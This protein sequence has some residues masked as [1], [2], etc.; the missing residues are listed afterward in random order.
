MIKLRP[1]KQKYAYLI[2]IISSLF[3]IHYTYATTNNYYGTTGDMYGN[4]WNTVDNTYSSA[5]DVTGG[6]ILNF[7]NATTTAIGPSS[8]ITV[9][10]INVNANV[11]IGTVGAGTITNLSNGAVTITVGTGNTFD[12]STQTFSGNATV[13][14]TKAGAGVFATNGNSYSGGF[15]LSAGTIMARGNN[16]MGNGGP[17][18][19]NGGTIAA[20]AARDFSGKYTGITIGGDFTLGSTTG[21][22]L[23]SA[24]LTFNTATSLGTAT[25]TITLG[26]TGAYTLSGV[27]SETSTAGLTVSSTAAGT[28]ILGGAN[29]YTGVTTVNSGVLLRLTNASALGTIAGNTVVNSGGGL[30]LN[31]INYST[32]EP[33]TINGTGISSAGAINNSGSAIATFAGPIT[34][35]TSS[36]INGGVYGTDFTGTVSG[37]G[38]LTITGSGG[39][40]LQGA[41]SYTGN[42]TKANTG[43]WTLSSTSNSYSGSTTLTAGTLCLG[44]AGVIP[45]GSSISFNGGTLCTGA[46]VGYTETVNL[47]NMT[48]S[49]TIALGTGSHNLI[50]ADSHAQSWTASTVL[51]IT[52]WNNT[53]GGRIYVGSNSSGL[54]SGQLAMITFSGYAAGAAINAGTGEITPAGGAVAPTLTADNSL[55]TVDNNIDITFSDSPVWRAAVTAVNIQISNTPTYTTL[56]AGTDY[57]LTSGHLL[58]KPSGG[59]S[60]LNSTAAINGLAGGVKPIVII[61]TGYANSTISQTIDNGVATQLSINAQPAAPAS[62]GAVLATQPVVKTLDQYG[63]GT[64]TTADVTATVSA[65]AWEIGGTLTQT[66][67]GRLTTFTDLVAY[68]DAAVTGATIIFSSTGLTSVTSGTFNIPV[69]TASP[70]LTAAV[71]ATVDAAFD[72][73]FTDVPAWRSAIRKITVGGTTLAAGAYNATV[74]GKI[75]F[76]PSVSTLLQSNGTKSI[77]I[78]STGYSSGTVSQAIGV[79]A[80]SASTSTA[81]IDANLSG[82]AT[83]TIT[84]TAKDQYNNLVSGYVFKYDATI[85]NSN[86]T[87]TES[88]TIDGVAKTA[89]ANDL[90]L[91]VTN[92]AG[93][94]TFTVVMPVTIDSGDGLVIQVQLNNGSTNVGSDFGNVLVAQTITFGALSNKINGD[95]PFALTATASS[96]LAVSYSSSDTNVATVS[97]STVTIVGVGS[98]TITASQAGDGSYTAA[99]S[100]PQGLNI[101]NTPNYTISSNTNISTLITSSTSDIVVA[102][103][104]TLTIDSNKLIHDL[105]VESGAKVNFSGAYTLSTVGNVI[106]KADKSTGSFSVNLGSGALGITGTSKFLKTMDDTKWFF[107]S[108]P[109]NIA[110]NNITF[111]GGYSYALGTDY[112]IKYYDGN[113]RI[114]NL[115]ASSNWKNVT[116]GSTLNAGDG[117]IFGLATGIG[118][119]REMIFPLTNA[120][121]QS[122]S[123]RT[124]NVT[125][126]GEGVTT[127]TL[128]NT[129]GAN[130]KGWN[131]V[132]QPYISKLAGTG[133]GVNYMTLY[134][135]SGYTTYAN[136]DVTTLD[137]FTSFFVQADAALQSSA[138]T[139]SLASRQS[140]PSS[141]KNDT[142]DK[143]RLYFQTPTGIDNTNLVLGDHQTNDYQIGQDMEKWITRGTDKPQVYTMLNGINYAFN[144]LPVA[145]VQNLPLGV[146]TNATGNATISTDAQSA[147]NLTQL[148]LTDT[149]NGTTTDLL[150]SIYSFTVDA[151]T[152]N[153]RFLLSA[154]RTSTEIPKISMVQAYCSVVSGKLLINKLTSKSK[155]MVYDA[156]GSL[157]ASELANSSTI[158]MALPSKGVY[159]VQFINAST[160]ICQKV[161][162]R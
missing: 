19:I 72:V 156:F 153:G 122:E 118:G 63:N 31:G 44:A 117:Y 133:V 80:V 40:S 71:G 22:A 99:S 97:G 138:V 161:I 5:M 115:G 144:A 160:T 85:T 124:V 159:I 125:A 130:H 26:G 46:T 61:A 95:V 47:L 75:T 110:V 20:T 27:I 94:K 39:G 129:V 119:D 78:Y 23:S 158:E 70:A 43:T 109:S 120:D 146:Y 131:L 60:Y 98:T 84:C 37:T 28:L 8:N 89:T 17:L 9:A 93:V 137:P 34:L 102:S 58:L 21:L 68:S 50:F 13:S 92:G 16:T 49:S 150:T 112:F 96:G 6:A 116:A 121:V 38:N 108:F 104:N 15:T 155:V 106:L 140:L 74:A 73:T 107:M 25:R 143:V 48:A 86:V 32:A 82:G 45:N 127:N 147:P 64:P 141:V 134:D 128:G 162:C 14:Y 105:T 55:N 3:S 100:V 90:T 152:N 149:S 114:Q 148:L 113:S 42:L 103:G 81:A 30:Q 132:G 1:M 12:A 88:Y 123:A 145:N 135:G 57:D 136:T 83:R 139:Y 67:S 87:T 18:T 154:Q 52:G 51:T 36:T 101:T 59:N 53:S 2:I 111:T 4:F 66:A 56:A 11:T 7:N 62:N 65:G 35:A 24:G 157:V 151:G 76:T 29:T 10:G 142:I 41:V 77:I 33:L 54:T 69:P 91:G 126:Y 79:G